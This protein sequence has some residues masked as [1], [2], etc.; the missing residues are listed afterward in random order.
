VAYPVLDLFFVATA[1]DPGSAKA[2]DDVEALCWRDPMTE[3]APEEMAF[4]S[5]RRALEVLRDE[6]EVA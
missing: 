3:V 6:R 1:R 5:V 2:L 4:D